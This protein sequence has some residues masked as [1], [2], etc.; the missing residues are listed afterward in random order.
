[1]KGSQRKSNFVTINIVIHILLYFFIRQYS[2]RQYCI[3][4]VSFIFI[5]Y[6]FFFYPLF[7][8]I[9][10]NAYHG[11]VC[12]F[13][14]FSSVRNYYSP[15]SYCSVHYLSFRFI[16]LTYHLKMP[17]TYKLLNCSL[18][19][20]IPFSSSHVEITLNFEAALAY[21]TTRSSKLSPGLRYSNGIV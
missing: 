18:L 10:C 9:S 14:I 5:I 19:Y 15:F 20:L 21:T 16:P 12:N 7:T 11:K 13:L 8:A 6:F 1:M 17:Y 3:Y 2:I 4:Y